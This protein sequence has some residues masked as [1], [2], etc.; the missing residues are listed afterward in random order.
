MMELGCTKQKKL[1]KTFKVGSAV[2]I[3]VANNTK[4]KKSTINMSNN[5]KSIYDNL[6]SLQYI[7]SFEFLL[8]YDFMFE[9]RIQQFEL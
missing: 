6:K 2:I 7:C 5:T 3:A 8:V 1:R 9:L 4:N